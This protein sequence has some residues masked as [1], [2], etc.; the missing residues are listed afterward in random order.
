ML[1]V[2]E[3]GVDVNAHSKA[4]ENKHGVDKAISLFHFLWIEEYYLSS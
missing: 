4:E 3:L 2:V 1:S